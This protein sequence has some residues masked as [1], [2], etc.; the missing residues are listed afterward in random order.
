M[1]V[2]AVAAAVMALDPT[3]KVLD[4]VAYAWAGFGAAFGPA[5]I[6]ALHWRRMT[7]GGALAGI[8]TGGIGVVIW[9]KL[10]GGPAGLFDVYELVPAFVLALLAIVIVSL[11]GRP[12]AA[13]IMTQHDAFLARLN[14]DPVPG[15]N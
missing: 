10:A 2:I 5:L 1:I 6:L 3:S 7:R 8:L 14:R 15:D 12:P 9:K 13:S 11:L 4:L